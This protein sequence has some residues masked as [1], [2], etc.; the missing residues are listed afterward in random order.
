MK[1]AELMLFFKALSDACMRQSGD[2]TTRYFNLPAAYYTPKN[3][4]VFSNRDSL[5]ARLDA[6][7]TF[8]TDRGITRISPANITV[9]ET[10]G[11]RALV[12]VDWEYL[13]G[14]GAQQRM[15]CAQ[16]VLRR[17]QVLGDLRIELVDYSVVAYPQF[18]EHMSSSSGR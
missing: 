14:H 16:Y 7:R 6:Y 4:H 9:I 3:L 2:V 5:A 8:L 13:N 17:G 1:R 12:Q 15:A 18:M 10:S 11:E